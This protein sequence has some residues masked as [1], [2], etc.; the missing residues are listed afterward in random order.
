MTNRRLLFVYLFAALA[1][2]G[3]LFM[4]WTLAMTPD[5][6]GGI[7]FVLSC[8]AALLIA[9]FPYHYFSFPND[10][11]PLVTHIVAT[12]LVWAVFLIF[13]DMLLKHDLSFWVSLLS[14]V[15]VVVGSLVLHA[16]FP[17]TPSMKEAIAA[18]KAQQVATEQE[19]DIAAHEPEAL[20]I[21]IKIP[22]Q[23]LDAADYLS[24]VIADVMVETLRPATLA[25]GKNQLT[26]TV[27]SGLERAREV[28]GLPTSS[29]REIQDTGHVVGTGAQSIGALVSGAAVGAGLSLAIYLNSNKE[30]AALSIGGMFMMFGLITAAFA[31]GFWLWSLM[32]ADHA[33]GRIAIIKNDNGDVLSMIVNDESLAQLER[34]AADSGVMFVGSPDR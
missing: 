20:L 32:R 11:A 12:P 34:Y 13:I 7:Y 22:N 6:Q 2:A 1:L 3:L 8:I 10:R 27:S 4:Y 15:G 25:V 28:A 21:P 5:I 18:K 9:P 26:I 19:A 33:E 31:F 29:I 23:A 30:N 17:G 24:E 16:F 14:F